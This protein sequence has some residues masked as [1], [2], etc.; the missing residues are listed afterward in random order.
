VNQ[1]VT[2]MDQVTQQ[3]AALVQQAA[4]AATQLEAEAARLREAVLR[5]RLAGQVHQAGQARAGR[6]SAGSPQV[7]SL[8]HDPLPTKRHSAQATAPSA[9]R[10]EKEEEQWASF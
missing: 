2:Q 1:A 10:N 9:K 8:S 4:T 5:F 3:N 6:A 7:A